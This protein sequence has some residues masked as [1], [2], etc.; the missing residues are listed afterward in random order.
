MSGQIIDTR[1][2]G[3]GQG[4]GSRK[5]YTNRAGRSGHVS[6]AIVVKYLK[7]M[8][9]PVN[10]KTMIS[11]AQSKDAT[12]DVID[13]ISKLPD[14]TYNSPIDITKEIGKIE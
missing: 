5:Q 8:G 7:G 10:K 9:Y 2:K 6:P 1:R 4:R 14:K 3:I 13:L 12:E 11:S